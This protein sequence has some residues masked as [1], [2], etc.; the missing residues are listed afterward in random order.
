M[1]AQGMPIRRYIA[2]W[3]E[4]PIWRFYSTCTRDTF[5][6]G[7]AVSIVRCSDSQRS[8]HGRH[9]QSVVQNDIDIRGTGN[10]RDRARYSAGAGIAQ[11][12]RAGLRDPIRPASRTTDPASRM[13]RA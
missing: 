10:V 4:T 9:G 2:P 12:R 11:V 1:E 5:V 3:F 13:R 7:S 6:A 8:R